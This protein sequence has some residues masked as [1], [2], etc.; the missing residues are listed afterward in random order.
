MNTTVQ[1]LYLHPPSRCSSHFPDTA[2]F[3][4][5]S[6][7]EDSSGMLWIFPVPGWNGKVW[8]MLEILAFWKAQQDYQNP[9]NHQTKVTV[10]TKK[11]QVSLRADRQPFAEQGIKRSSL[12]LARLNRESFRQGTDSW[13]AAQVWSRMAGPPWGC[14]RQR[15]GD[16]RWASCLSVCS[17]A[18]GAK[19]RCSSQVCTESVV[20]ICSQN[21]V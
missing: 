4:L 20:L 7:G 21:M 14:N 12:S 10:K 16:G 3:T 2:S 6:S 18:S 13:K 1:V 5:L 8:L 19:P 11:T 15:D 9:K 17:K